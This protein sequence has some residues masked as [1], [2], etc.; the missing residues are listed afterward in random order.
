MHTLDEMVLLIS[1]V[2]IFCSLAGKD[3]QNGFFYTCTD[4][5]INLDSLHT[6]K[7]TL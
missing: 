2:E 7:P 6:W 1:E 3:L 4:L 5:L